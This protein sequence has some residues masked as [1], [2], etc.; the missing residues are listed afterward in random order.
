VSLFDVMKDSGA[1]VPEDD[2]INFE[3]ICFECNVVSERSQYDNESGIAKIKC[4][5]G[6]ESEVYIG[7]GR[8]D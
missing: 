6:E 7:A 8:E 4:V 3:I 5:C 2:F 1:I